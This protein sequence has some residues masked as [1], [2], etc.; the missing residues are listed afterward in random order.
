M[1]LLGFLAILGLRYHKCSN[2]PCVNT[3]ELYIYNLANKIIRDANA[4]KDKE[5]VLAV[6]DWI[7]ANFINEAQDKVAS[8]WRE[9]LRERYGSCQIRSV[10]IRELLAP[11]GVKSRIIQVFNFNLNHPEDSHVVCEAYYD[12]NWHLFD[13]S[14]GV[15]YQY[16]NKAEILSFSE[17]IDTQKEVQARFPNIWNRV[18]LTTENKR[19]NYDE[20]DD[21]SLKSK[22]VETML[23]ALAVPGFYKSIRNYSTVYFDGIGLAIIEFNGP[24]KIGKK[25]SGAKSKWTDLLPELTGRIW[26]GSTGWFSKEPQCRTLIIKVNNLVQYNNY[27]L[28]LSFGYMSLAPATVFLQS[29]GVS[30]KGK[31]MY[32]INKNGYLDDDWAIQFQAESDKAVIILTLTEPDSYLYLDALEFAYDKEKIADI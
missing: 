17:L 29:H 3:E 27:K 14:F 9:N 5:K 22:S 11:I 2:N 8:N 19:L 31:T 20:F 32:N 21:N 26:F 13:P 6:N 16:P 28:K 30:V 18:Q 12:D 1:L 10:I 23:S 25:E 15:F 4:L 24:I 7:A